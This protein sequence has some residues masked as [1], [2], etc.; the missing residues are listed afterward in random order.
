MGTGIPVT[1]DRA[2]IKFLDLC[3]YY[4]IEGK[5]YSDHAVITM[6]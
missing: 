1:V 6:M 2:K 5:G 4:Y 3:L